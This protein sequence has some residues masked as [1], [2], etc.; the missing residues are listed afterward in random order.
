MASRS[1]IFVLSFLGLLALVGAAELVRHGIAMSGDPRRDPDRVGSDSAGGYLGP[2]EGNLDLRK[3]EFGDLARTGRLLPFAERR[4]VRIKTDPF[5][6]WNHG[7]RPGAAYDAVLLGDCMI[8]GHPG[9]M[10]SDYMD[11]ASGWRTYNYHDL[12]AKALLADG[13]FRSAPP[14]LILLER[15]ERGFDAIWIRHAFQEFGPGEPT[16]PAEP[17]DPSLRRRLG[18]LRARFRHL[19]RRL[20]RDL[21]VSRHSLLR[22]SLQ[23]AVSGIRYGVTGR[24]PRSVPIREPSLG[25]L[26]HA[27]ELAARGKSAAERGLPE[28]LDSLEAYQALC[29]KRGIAFAVMLVPDKLSIYGRGIPESPP[30]RSGEFHGALLAGLRERDIP[31]VDLFPAFRERA[32][33]GD[34]LLYARD[35]TRWTPLARRLAAREIDR[36]L[37]IGMGGPMV[38]AR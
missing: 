21:D 36:Q 30:D 7:Y 26:F 22:E 25:L 34:S 23:Y 31:A 19:R 29:R 37:R 28:M 18:E 5:G 6:F 27:E 14:R 10:L 1:R 32:L 33:R 4:E 2:W 38:G 17:T 35:D 16:E 13:R 15:V 9:E 11:S 24:M 8:G 3:T 20:A 12:P